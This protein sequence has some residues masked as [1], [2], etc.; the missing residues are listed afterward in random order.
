[1]Y[2]CF[3][4][5]FPSLRSII[6]NPHASLG[7]SFVFLSFIVWSSL[8]RLLYNALSRS[9]NISHTDRSQSYY[10]CLAGRISWECMGSAVQAF[11]NSLR[12][13]PPKNKGG[14]AKNEDGIMEQ[15]WYMEPGKRHV[16]N[17]MM[18]ISNTRISSPIIIVEPTKCQGSVHCILH[19]ASHLLFSLAPFATLSNCLL[20]PLNL[21][22]V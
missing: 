3:L 19:K 21:P 18:R 17:I 8:N 11:F 5:V 14:T 6:L 13:Y 15:C 2:L 1:M 16:L 10:I 9:C 20:A 12:C 4:C 22:S 7:H